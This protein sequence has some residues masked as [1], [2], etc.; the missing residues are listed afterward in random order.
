[1]STFGVRVIWLVGLGAALTAIRSDRAY[2]QSAKARIVRG[3]ITDSV[4]TRIS[5]VN[6]SVGSIRMASG[7]DG[8][9]SLQVPNDVTAAVTFRRVGFR[10]VELRLAPG[11]DT[12]VA[13]VLAPIAERLEAVRVSTQLSGALA[14]RG[15]YE[16]M[17][18]RENGLNTGWF[19]TPEEIELRGRPNMTRLF[20]NI[21]GMRVQNGGAKLGGIPVGVRNGGC[22]MATY[23]DGLRLEVFP[24]QGLR[25]GTGRLAAR[26]PTADAAA[27]TG[28]D[29][30]ISTTEV[31]GIE[32]YTNITSAPGLYQ[33]LNGNC[34]VILIWTK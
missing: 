7:A 10:P 3:V 30:F 16:R 14:R 25:E 5:Y 13:I 12:S 8:T 4:A 18:D 28:L 11:G 32:V 15:F 17:R 1:M 26:S 27:H 34:G 6:I 21:A 33:P 23:L 31:A 19:I 22:L 20:E 29:N 2:G 24:G 9:F